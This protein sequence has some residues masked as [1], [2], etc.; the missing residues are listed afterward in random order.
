MRWQW[1]ARIIVAAIGVG[2]AVAIAISAHRRS[3]PPEPVTALQDI[4]ANVVAKGG[5]GRTQFLRKDK[6]PVNL[7]SEGS[8]QDRSGRKFFTGALVEG[9]EGDPE[10]ISHAGLSLA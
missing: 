2:A 6:N 1:P 8:E 10:E 7:T 9:L 4:K 3:R 5:A